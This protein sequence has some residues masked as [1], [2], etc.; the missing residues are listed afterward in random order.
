MTAT[1]EVETETWLCEVI[2]D[3]KKKWAGFSTEEF[4]SPALSKSCAGDV[5]VA[6]VRGYAGLGV[7]VAVLSEIRLPSLLLEDSA[8]AVRRQTACHQSPHPKG[9]EL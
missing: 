8:P 6:L 1:S 4:T 5:N 9:G 2:S 3:A 7:D